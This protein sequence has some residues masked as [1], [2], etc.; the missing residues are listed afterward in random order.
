MPGVS[1]LALAHVLEIRDSMLE[2][3]SDR[4][5]VT[6]TF[7]IYHFAKY[8]IPCYGLK[9]LYFCKVGNT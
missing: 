2:D 5:L 4:I 3:P 9:F 6:L 8:T 7:D 1:L